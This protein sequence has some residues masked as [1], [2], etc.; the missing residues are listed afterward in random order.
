LAAFLDPTIYNLLSDDDRKSAK[1][2]IFKRLNDLP[3]SNIVLPSS[4]TTTTTSTI[5][6]SSALQKLA[7]LC[8]H[9]IN[10]TT[11]TA[12]KR[13]MTIDE[14]LS[15]YIEAARS[16]TSFQEF[17]VNHHKSLPRLARLVRRV[18]IIPASSVASERLFSIGSFLNRKQRSSLSSQTLRYLLD[19]KDQH[20]LDK[21]Q[22]DY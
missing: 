1:K 16:A 18:C 10:L 17:W 13:P 22:Q 2:L 21:L 4:S 12:S 15:A 5:T 19:L 8:G 20:I 6:K 14:E 3:T 9:N 11:S 7:L